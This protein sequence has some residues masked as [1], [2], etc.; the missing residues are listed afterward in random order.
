LGYDSSVIYY[1]KM[2]YNNKAY[3]QIYSGNENSYS[4]NI[5]VYGVD[6]NFRLRVGNS[7]GY[8][9]YSNILTVTFNTIPNTMNSPILSEMNTD[10]R[11]NLIPYIKI[12]WSNSNNDLN[13]IISY[14]LEYKLSTDNDDSI[15]TIYESTNTNTY[16]YTLNTQDDNISLG[17]IY[18]F[19]ISC[20]NEIGYSER[21]N[22]LSVTFA[23]APK[24]ITSISYEHTST[25]YINIIYDI[26]N[27]YNG[28]S[29]VTGYYLKY[30]LNSE[31]D[32]NIITINDINTLNYL[33]ED[34]TNGEKYNFNISAFNT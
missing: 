27:T 29:E 13:E 6:Y 25:T 33:I 3:T 28:G 14:K 21:S 15:T 19:Y 7:I 18:Y 1:L 32:Y 34:L 10:N 30:K 8:S 26:T 9:E 16:D 24:Q 23:S 4:F 5:P 2:S 20:S 22:Y 11:N 17:N 12:I 31:S